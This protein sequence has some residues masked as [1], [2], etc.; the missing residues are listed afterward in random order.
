MEKKERIQEINQ[1]IKD[2]LKTWSDICL[3]ADADNW[4]YRLDYDKRD[5]FS[6]TQLFMHVCQNIGIKKGRI[7]EKAAQVYG[8]RIRELVQSMTGY[9]TWHLLDEKEKK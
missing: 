5:V 9:D 7:N 6:V 1:H 2:G 3:M 8:E 4:S